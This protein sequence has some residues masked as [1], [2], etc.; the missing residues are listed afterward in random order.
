MWLKQIV[1]IRAAAVSFSSSLTSLWQQRSFPVQHIFTRKEAYH[2]V[3]Y[4]S[5]AG[6]AANTANSL[7]F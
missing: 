4:D 2:I 7:Y 6:V 1:F 5:A 3:Y